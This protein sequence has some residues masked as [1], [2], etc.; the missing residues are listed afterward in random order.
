VSLQKRWYPREIAH[1]ID[2]INISSITFVPTTPP[3]PWPNFHKRKRHTST[4]HTQSAQQSTCPL[5]PQTTKHLHRKQRKRAAEY[6]SQNSIRRHSASAI[7]WPVRISDVHH[8]RHEDEHV[9]VAEKCFGDGGHDPMYTVC[10][11]PAEE[12]ETDGYNGA[13]EHG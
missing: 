9:S 12:E 7:Q 1:A 8:A 2:K 5:R 3:Q 11:G 4:H 6:V 10:S 13:A